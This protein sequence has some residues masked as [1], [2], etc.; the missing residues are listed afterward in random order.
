[1]VTNTCARHGESLGSI[2]PS[3][4]NRLVSEALKFVSAVVY[5]RDLIAIG[6]QSKDKFAN[7]KGGDTSAVVRAFR[8]RGGFSPPKGISTLVCCLRTL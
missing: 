1:M 6:L 3:Y 2:I 5:R 4:S 8:I 7:S